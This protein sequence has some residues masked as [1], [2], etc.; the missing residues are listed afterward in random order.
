MLT[1]F[2]LSFTGRRIG[3]FATNSCW[4]ISS[5]LKYVTTL[6]CEISMLKNRS[7]QDVIKANCHVTLSHSK[8]C[9]KIFV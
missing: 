1:D 4:N 9:F 6:P 5:R 8:N 7:A 3:K 2:Q